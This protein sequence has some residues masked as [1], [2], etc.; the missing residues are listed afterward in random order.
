MDE[1]KNVNVVRK[2]NIYFDGKVV[3]RTVLFSNGEK[4]TLGFM[5]MGEYEFQTADKEIMEIIS[6]SLEVNIADS[7]DWKKIKGGE[8]FEVPSNSKFKMKVYEV[9]DYICHFIKD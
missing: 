7:K 9:S 4:K 5:Q 3:S 1:F 2:G 6:G 8:S